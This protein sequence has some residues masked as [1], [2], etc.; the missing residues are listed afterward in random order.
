M[1][2]RDHSAANHEPIP[3]VLSS[4]TEPATDRYPIGVQSAVYS[5]AFF[6]GTVQSMASTI[7]ALLVVALID[8]NLALLVGVI[9]ASRQFL[10]VTMSVYAGSLMDNFGT[11]RVIIVF[12]FAG[13]L[14]A[15]A[16][17]SLSLIFGVEV[18]S[19]LQNPGVMFVLAIILVQMVSGYAEG[20]SWIGSQTLV[21]QLMKGHPVYAGRMT[22]VARIGG[23]LGPP[24]IGYA[25]DFWG[26]WGGFGFLA[27]WIAGGMIAASFLPDTR[28]A[29]QGSRD[30][31]EAEKNDQPDSSGTT[32]KKQSSY[33]ETLRLLLIPAVAMVIMATVMRQTGSGVQSSFY[34]VWLSE[35]V[36]IDGSTIGWLIGAANGASAVAALCTGPLMR[37]YSAHWLLLLM[38]TVSVIA[39]A[40]TPLFGTNFTTLLMITLLGAICVRGFAQGLNL[41]LMMI[42]LSRSVA[43]HLQG[44]VTALRISFNRFGGL[45]VPP[46]MGALADMEAV[47]GLANAFYIVGIAGVVALSLLALWVFLSPS[48]RKLG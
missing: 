4:M 5:T 6:N 18:G 20:S 1:A 37:R 30:A 34:V 9:L 25:W 28:A 10:T 42:I 11:K 21:G 48:F 47:G 40:I 13:V 24:A 45:L 36:G 14:A 35:H 46:G 31:A 39:I 41:P 33:G 17:P 44:R 29:T 22:F 3:Y 8:K 32:P 16:Y 2:P 15:L 27:A 38:V 19:S 43:P 12:G 26:P 23:F 7:V